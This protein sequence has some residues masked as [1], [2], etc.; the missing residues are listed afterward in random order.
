[1]SCGSQRDMSVLTGTFFEFFW[2]ECIEDGFN[3]R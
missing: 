1:M 3:M 2:I